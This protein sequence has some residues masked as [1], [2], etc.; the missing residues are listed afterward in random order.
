MSESI[1]VVK[2]SFAL[3]I[4]PVAVGEAALESPRQRAKGVLSNV[5]STRSELG[6]GSVLQVSP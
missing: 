1:G 3:S 4:D 5:S 6:I 2:E